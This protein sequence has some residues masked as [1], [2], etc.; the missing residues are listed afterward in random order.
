MYD[1]E[2]G[3]PHLITLYN[4]LSACPG[5][6]GARFSGA[7][8]RGSCIGLIDPAYRDQIVATIDERYPVAHPDV[9]DAYSVHFCQTGG[10]A[11][12]WQDYE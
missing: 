4:I 2:S 8:F 1:Y 9:A 5:V 7:G 11:C 10:P 3:C 6:Y 12:Q